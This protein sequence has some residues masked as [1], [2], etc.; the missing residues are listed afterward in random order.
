MGT[1]VRI[2]P[3][4]TDIIQICTIYE[5]FLLRHAILESLFISDNSAILRLILKPSI[6]P[7]LKSLRYPSAYFTSFLGLEMAA[8]LQF[9]DTRISPETFPSLMEMK[10]L[11]CLIVRSCISFNV[12]VL[13]GILPQLERLS[14]ND[15]TQ[16]QHRI[17]YLES[18]KDW[19]RLTHL[20]GYF[21]ALHLSNPNGENSLRF[22][23]RLPA[24]KYIEVS[25][26]PPEMGKTAWIELKRDE[27]GEYAGYEW[28]DDPDIETSAWGNMFYG[29]SLCT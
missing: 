23:T 1:G 17:F 4:E 2:Y 13:V 25:V 5:E 15:H 20:G 22:I 12:S 16:H 6:A 28:T 24:L 19:T 27:E 3:N 11:K 10:Q 18:W 7:S 21:A 9:F 26:G 8:Q 29:T 14:L